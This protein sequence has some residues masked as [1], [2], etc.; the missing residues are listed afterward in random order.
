MRDRNQSQAADN[1]DLSAR[2]ST[3]VQPLAGFNVL[4]RGRHGSFV[5]NRNDIYVGR[6]LIDYGEYSEIEWRMLGQ[7]CRAGDVVVEVG[8]NIGALTVPMAKAVGATGRVIAIEPQP[9][10]YQTLCAN[11]ALNCLLNVEARNFGCGAAP[12][13]LRLPPIDYAVEN[14]F[15]AVPLVGG[16]KGPPVEVCRLDDVFKLSRLRLIKVDV[17][18]MEVEV[19]EGAR[20]VIERFSPILYLEND[21]VDRSKRLIEL[22]LQL[23]YRLW[24]HLPPLFNPENHFSSRENTFGKLVSINML[25][26]HG[27]RSA[28]VRDLQEVTDS[29][30]HPLAKPRLTPS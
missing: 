20:G 16:D 17:E 9:V 22:I 19:L 5:A 26:L 10:V 2:A 15:G 24:W 30:F 6:A 23:G 27:S 11:L 14:N 29:E 3:R 4:V 13:T 7:L 21:R 18:G 8:A 28:E 25:C 12:G 1:P